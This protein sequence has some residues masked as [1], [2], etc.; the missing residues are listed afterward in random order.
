MKRIVMIIA[1]FFLTILISACSGQIITS[2]NYTLRS[3]ET[4]NGDLTMTSGNAVL[5]SNSHVTGSILMTSGNLEVNGE[6]DG[7]I[8]ITSGDVILGAEAFVHGDISATSGDIVQADGAR[9]GGQVFTEGAGLGINIIGNLFGQIFIL[10]LVVIALIVFFVLRPGQRRQTVAKRTGEAE[11]SIVDEETIIREGGF[12]DKQNNRVIG[13]IVLI[14]LGVLFLLSQ[15]GLLSL[16]GNWWAIFIALPA[17]VMLYN[18]FTGYQQAGQMTAE[19]RRNIS[20]GV[21]VGTVA[22]IALTGQWGTLWP[23]FLIVPGVMMLLGF[24]KQ[25]D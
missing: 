5:E 23:L 1:L 17:A 18:A 25:N 14:G 8:V 21:I 20:G 2:G 3:G 6:V 24:T 9:V 15:S 13:G 11:E 12:M 4:L 22:V 7:D 19:V 16:S 10:P